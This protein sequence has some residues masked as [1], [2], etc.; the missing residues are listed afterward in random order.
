MIEQAKNNLQK[1]SGNGLI[2]AGW[3]VAI[4]AI[5]NAILIFLFYKN[6]I[7]TDFSMLVWLL[8]IPGHIINY[9]L[10][11]KRERKSM[12]KT[13][14]DSIIGSVWKGFGYSVMTLLVVA[15]GIG[16]IMQNLFQIVFLII[17]AM[18]I[19]TGTAGYVTAKAFRFSPYG[20][21]VMWLG[22]LA[23]IGAMRFQYPFPIISHFFIFAICM[24]SGGLVMMGYQL[25]KLA[26]KDV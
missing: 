7:H 15:G 4:L 5:L 2:F 18:L 8:V 1:G 12:V 6:G 13:H 24:I 19:M 23:C 26:K 21:I 25:N 20:A 16:F 22:A 14:I 17:P 11:K 10:Q 3:M 9:L